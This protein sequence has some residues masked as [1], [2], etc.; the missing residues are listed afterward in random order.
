[1]RR[2]SLGL[3][4]AAVAVALALALGEALV[5]AIVGPPARILYTGSFRDTQT[6]F[7]VA[8]GVAP[9]GLRKTCGPA[10][11]PGDAGRVAVLGDSFV[12]GQGVA[13]CEDFVSLLNL[14]SRD[15]KRFQNFGIIASA[16]EDYRLVARDLLADTDEV[17]IVFFGNDVRDGG[18]GRTPAGRLADH[19]SAL[20]L[21]RRARR[22]WILYRIRQAARDAGGTIAY[23]DGRPNQILSLI[24]KSP[25]SLRAMVEPTREQVEGFRERFAELAGDLVRRFGAERVWIS[26]VP[27]GQTVSLRLAEFIREQGGAVAPFGAPGPA[28]EL[29]RD[30]SRQHG[31]RFVDVF[32]GFVPDG[33]ELYHPHDLHWTAAGHRRMAELLAGPLG[34]SAPARPAAAQAREA[35]AVPSAA[36]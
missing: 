10:P 28:Y 27:D 21:L 33:D 6:D 13:D 16:I 30:L 1:V 9:R 5:R 19:S 12:F 31:L 25:D 24:R 7:D 4:A 14:G 23:L 36:P 29:V 18:P 22:A 2:V 11:G 34:L 17:V 20:S 26:C 15:D 3:A 32:P 8:Y 35:P